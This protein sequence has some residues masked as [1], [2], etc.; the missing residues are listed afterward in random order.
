MAGALA[1]LS[2][3]LF[4]AYPGSLATALASLEAGEVLTVGTFFAAS[5]G[6][7]VIGL[8]FVALLAALATVFASG[9]SFSVWIDPSGTVSNTVGGPVAGAVAVLEQAPTVEGPFTRVGPASPGMQPHRN[10]EKT[11]VDGQFHWDVISDYYKVVASAP[12]CHA[13]GDPA[14]ATVSTPALP[15]PPP[16]VGLDLVLQCAHQG[17][18]ERPLVTSLSSGE[19]LEK[20]GAKI[21][22]VGSHFTPSA[23][24]RFG[25]APAP[26]VTFE[27]PAALVG[28]RP[29][30]EGHR[31][32]GCDNRGR[33]EPCRRPAR[34]VY[35]RAPAITK[36]SPGSG[37][38]GRGTRVTIFGTGLNNAEVVTVGRTSVTNFTVKS[39]QV[40]ELTVPSG[41]PGPVDI[42]VTTPLGQSAVS[43]ADRYTYLP[44]R[45]LR[46]ILLDLDRTG[47]KG[48]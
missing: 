3:V 17:A 41:R 43:R 39:G 34:F 20:G 10:P 15:V 47:K 6:A 26:S 32:C 2:G 44:A 30:R 8:G 4:T 16:Q 27:S 40:I 14:Q 13:P 22:V 11:G 33:D 38:P 19:A 42:T 7:L 48:C 18:P 28:Q 24:V 21:E 46:Q 35:G 23:T 12:G 37:P 36:V 1:T 9:T 31:Q 29:A 25:Q 5:A 45:R